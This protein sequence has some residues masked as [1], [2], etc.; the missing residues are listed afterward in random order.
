MIAK[1]A[2]HRSVQPS[3]SST[4]RNYTKLV[5]TETAASNRS[6]RVIGMTHRFSASVCNQHAQPDKAKT[7]NKR[8]RHIS[9]LFPAYGIANDLG[10]SYQT[11]NRQ[12]DA[13]TNPEA[14]ADGPPN[15]LFHKVK[16]LGC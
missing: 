11:T 8:N 5:D 9:K 6:G 13:A 1:A 3:R 14:G 10:Q 16:Q 2:R 7:L 12:F 4:S 15:K